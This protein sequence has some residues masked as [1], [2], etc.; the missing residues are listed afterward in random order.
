MDRE[1]GAAGPGPGHQLSGAGGVGWGGVAG[2]EGD[3]REPEEE[4][5]RC[6]S[7][8]G[9]GRERSRECQNVSVRLVAVAGYCG[10]YCVYVRLQ[11]AGAV[12]VSLGWL[13]FCQPRMVM[14]VCLSTWSDGVCVSMCTHAHS[15]CVSTHGDEGVC[16]LQVAVCGWGVCVC[17]CVCPPAYISLRSLCVCLPACGL[18]ACCVS[19]WWF[20]IDAWVVNVPGLAVCVSFRVLT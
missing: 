10:P 19:P 4:I 2:S 17:V 20:C 12:C 11:G 14:G 5:W 7:S 6:R 18:N 16:L 8:E 13:C 9:S 3:V 15:P 1:A